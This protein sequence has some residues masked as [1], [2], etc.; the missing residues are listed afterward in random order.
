MVTE[1]KRIVREAAETT[2][3][4]KASEPATRIAQAAKRRRTKQREAAARRELF[5]SASTLSLSLSSRDSNGSDAASSV[6]RSPI[7][8]TV[9]EEVDEQSLRHM[10]TKDLAFFGTQTTETKF[11]NYAR[12]MLA[13]GCS[14]E[15]LYRQKD[16]AVG[17]MH[18]DGVSLTTI[19][20]SLRVPL[21]GKIYTEV[22]AA[23]AHPVILL[24]TA[25]RNEW[26]CSKLKY[27][28]ENRESVLQSFPSGREHAKV[29]VLAIL[30]GGNPLSALATRGVS[31]KGMVIPHFFT[32]LRREIA[33]I[34]SHVFR[35]HPELHHAIGPAVRSPE[36]SCMSF[37]LQNEE[38]RIM[39]AAH[40]FLVANSWTIGAF[41]YDG[42]L[43]KLHN[44]VGP[45]D[46]LLCKL[47]AHV[48]AETSYNLTFESKPLT[49]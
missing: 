7:Q 12:K 8:V 27:Y 5:S 6:T 24:E 40:A 32:S 23:N 20:R 41:V 3:A 37:F 42:L 34:R 39:L 28:V 45:S 1:Q 14:R 35:A 46:E 47:S 33:H 16:H 48:A 38:L 18:S 36:I 9:V 31:T 10:L 30:M 21:A 25:R 13:H 29:V 19:N 22:D 17:R 2:K 11:R 43:V 49:V 44:G 26:P 15:L 4:L